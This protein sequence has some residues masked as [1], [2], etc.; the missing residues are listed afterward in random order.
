MKLAREGRQW[1]GEQV[2]ELARQG[3]VRHAPAAA[4]GTV[5]VQAQALL[6]GSHTDFIWW[7]VLTVGR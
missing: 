6:A 7:R 2:V 4:T 1:Q 3:K 5:D